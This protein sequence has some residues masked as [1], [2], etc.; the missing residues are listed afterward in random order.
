MIKKFLLILLIIF[1]ITPI[2]HLSANVKDKGVIVLMYHRF[3][4]NRY[5][6]TNI[7]MSDFIKQLDLIKKNN[8]KF[9]SAE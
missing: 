2:D 8:F 7:K 6:S 3:D 9:I 4:E 5:P 1:I